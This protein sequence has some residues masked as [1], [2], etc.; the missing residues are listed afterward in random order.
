MRFSS[1]FAVLGVIS[2]SF[3]NT[4]NADLVTSYVSV[5]AETNPTLSPTNT[6]PGVIATDLTAGNGITPF[7]GTGDTYNWSGWDGPANG[8]DSAVAAGQFWTWGFT[9]A[10]NFVLDLTSLDIRL[11][12]SPGGPTS[13]QLRL[14]INGNS[15]SIVLASPRLS[16]N[17]QS[18][19]DVDLS[20][21]RSNSGLTAGDTLTFTLAAWGTTN[22][23]GTLD[24]ENLPSGVGLAVYGDFTTAA[25]PE[26]SQL[27]FGSLATVV[28][29]VKWVGRRS[30]CRRSKQQS[31]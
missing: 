11:D 20:L 17:G 8:F 26:A 15:G 7:T 29:G 5:R 4:A 22:S 10:P 12:R 6:N 30:R 21:A 3:G 28:F 25:V 16:E 13:F 18:F 24:L 2:A 27:V 14:S 9:V 23:A 1:L 31:R 19:T